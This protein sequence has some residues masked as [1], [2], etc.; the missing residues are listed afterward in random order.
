MEQHGNELYDDDCEEEKHEDN[1][2]WLK[3]QILFGDNDLGKRELLLTVGTEVMH[4]VLV[5]WFVVLYQLLICGLSH[6]FLYECHASRGP[7]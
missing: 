6:A 2:D 3:M 4:A 1:S 5:Y 7:A